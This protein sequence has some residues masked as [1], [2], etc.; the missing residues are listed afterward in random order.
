MGLPTSAHGNDGDLRRHVNE[1]TLVGRISVVLRGSDVP[2]ACIEQ[3]VRHDSRSL[4]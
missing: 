1:E 2:A 3:Y 4:R